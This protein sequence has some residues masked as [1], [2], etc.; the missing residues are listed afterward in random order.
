MLYSIFFIVLCFAVLIHN[1]G[2]FFKT[3]E[4]DKEQ[5]AVILMVLPFV[6]VFLWILLT[7]K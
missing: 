6:V 2:K 5:V 1:L 4:V 7:F 3:G